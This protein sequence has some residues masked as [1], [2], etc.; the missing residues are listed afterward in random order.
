M[1]EL[2][3]AG[4]EYSVANVIAISLVD[5]ITKEF[6]QSSTAHRV[7]RKSLLPAWKLAT[8]SA[9]KMDVSQSRNPGPRRASVRGSFSLTTS[10][11]LAAGCPLQSLE[12]NLMMRLAGL[13]SN[14]REINPRPTAW[15]LI[16]AEWVTV[17]FANSRSWPDNG[18][19]CRLRDA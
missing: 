15:V 14:V 8:D 7:L 6:R 19:L 13:G 16:L 17:G 12:T 4:F 2:Q 1:S 3:S 11:R 5:K 10:Q 18:G 9:G